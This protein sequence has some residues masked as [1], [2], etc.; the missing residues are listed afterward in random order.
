MDL[1][2]YKVSAIILKIIEIVTSQDSK[3]A[4]SHHRLGK[5]NLNFAPNCEWT[6]P[7][8]PEITER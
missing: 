1:H 2:L 5:S 7:N 8:V 3:S 6:L 4:D